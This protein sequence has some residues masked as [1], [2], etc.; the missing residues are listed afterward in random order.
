MVSLESFD[1]RFMNMIVTVEDKLQSQLLQ[2]VATK[3]E[4]AGEASRVDKKLVEAQELISLNKKKINKSELDIN[5]IHR[6]LSKKLGQE[7]MAYVK[8]C[9]G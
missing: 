2:V 5:E 9:I 6:T 4:L 3:E 8:D 1:S 7:D